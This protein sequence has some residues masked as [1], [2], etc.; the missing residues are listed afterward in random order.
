MRRILKFAAVNIIATLIGGGIPAMAQ[1]GYHVYNRGGMQYQSADNRGHLER[2][3]RGNRNLRDDGRGDRDRRDYDRRDE[4]P[5]YRNDHSYGYGYA[6]AP[7]YPAAPFYAGPV[8]D[9]GSYRQ[10]THNGRTVADH[11]NPY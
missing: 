5:A 4:S 11:H 9:D 8:Y 10:R 2:N 1:D 7:V 6:P 3:D